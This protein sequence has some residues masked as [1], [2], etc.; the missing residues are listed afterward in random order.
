[1][2][3]ATPRTLAVN[4][5]YPGY[6]SLIAAPTVASTPREIDIACD[7]TAYTDVKLVWADIA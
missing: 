3:D 2:P 6:A 5:N 1:M 7:G 4:Q